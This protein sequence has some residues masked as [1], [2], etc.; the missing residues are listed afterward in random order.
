MHSDITFFIQI[1]KLEHNA[2][3]TIPE[4]LF[5]KNPELYDVDLSENK[6][7]SLGNEFAEN[8]MLV[9]LNLRGNRIGKVDKKKI[10]QF[11]SNY[12]CFRLDKAV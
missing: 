4:N 10:N 3:E 1:V 2:V 9:N 11:F 8:G 12:I 6:L 7:K 5:A